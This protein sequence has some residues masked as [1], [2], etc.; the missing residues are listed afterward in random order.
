MTSRQHSKLTTIKASPVLFLALGCSVL[1]PSAANQLH[2]W[3]I[4]VADVPRD[5]REA[6]L[7]TESPQNEVGFLHT[8]AS[9]SAH[10]SSFEV[11]V[12]THAEFTTPF[13]NTIAVKMKSREAITA[14]LNGIPQPQN[15]TCADLNEMSLKVG[16]GMLNTSERNSYGV[17]TKQ[18]VFGPDKQYHTGLWDFSRIQISENVSRSSIGI[19]SP[20][21]HNS[22]YKLPFGVGGVFYCRLLTASTIANWIRHQ[23]NRSITNH[24]GPEVFK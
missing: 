9:I 5:E 22:N 6:L 23:L 4:A 7:V 19:V 8:K 21:F 10:N 1:S 12:V 18:L 14:A 13:S 11:I 2:Q 24:T 15:V 20:C 3:Q 16:L 17:L